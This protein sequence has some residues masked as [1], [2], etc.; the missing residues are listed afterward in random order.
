MTGLPL[1]SVITPCFKTERY[2]ETFLDQ[3]S[4]QTFFE[5]TQFVLDLNAPNQ[6]ERKIINKYLNIYPERIK[7]LYSEKVANISTSMNRAIRNSDAKFVAIWNVDDLRTNNSL[8]V[9]YLTMLASKKLSFTVDSYEVVSKFGSQSG[10]LVKHEDIPENMLL[11]GMYL[12]PFFMFSKEL[13]DQIGYF[14]EQLYSGADFDFA[15]RLARATTPVYPEGVAGYYL[16]EGLGASTRPNSLQPLERTVIELR[17]GIFHKIDERFVYPASQYVIPAIL[18]DG[19]FVELS[20]LF[21]DYNNYVRIKLE[22]TE[23][24]EIESYSSKILK[25]LYFAFIYVL[26]IAIKGKV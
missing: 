12:G 1:V 25:K 4:E 18:N 21:K 24:N 14:D 2:L 5:Q 8:E 16:D 20:A 3:L 6:L 10:R 13:I 19:Q 26:K 22:Q 23:R 11:T 7:V 15:V 9:Q 17:Y